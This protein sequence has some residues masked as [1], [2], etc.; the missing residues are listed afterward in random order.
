MHFLRHKLLLACSIFAF[1]MVPCF[2][3]IGP[4]QQP[5]DAAGTQFPGVPPQLRPNAQQHVTGSI[6]GSVRTLSNKP[7]SNARVDITSLQQAQPVATEYTSNSGNF[8]ISGLP[9]GDYELRAVS[10][11]LEASE[12]VQVSDGQSWVTL[13]MPA[14]TAQGGNPNGATVSVQ[15]LRVPDKA[16][17]FLRKAHEA[18][19]KNRLNDANKYLSMALGVYPQYAQALATRGILEL[20][21]GQAQQAAHDANRAIQADPS[22]GTAYLVMGAALNVQKKFQDA[23]RS[24]SR[25]EELVPN[26]WQ[27]YF[28]S[29]KALM[30]LGRFQEALQQINK[31]FTLVDPTQHPELHVVKGYAY[32]ALRIYS[33]ALA[34]FEAYVTQVPYGPYTAA[35]R[36]TLKKIRPLAATAVAR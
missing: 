24:L 31:A 35:V 4:M 1:A 5:G 15:Q 30:Q 11:V 21:Q 17:S 34:E 23:L 6:T 8:A 27:G 16:V 19:D 28:E 10:G 33:P 29:S 26:A 9:P 7:V 3:Q 25:A 32:M 20:Q 12:R 22:Y 13:R 14:P 36:N 18:M 2:G